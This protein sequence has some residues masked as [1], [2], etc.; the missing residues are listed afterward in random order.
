MI[1]EAS[2]ADHSSPWHQNRAG[3][4][5]CGC[6]HGANLIVL[7]PSQKDRR[8]SDRA[9]AQALDIL[10][11]AVTAYLFA[12]HKNIDFS[13]T[14]GI[15]KQESKEDLNHR[16]SGTGKAICGGIEEERKTW[17][18]HICPKGS[19]LCFQHRS[20]RT[21]HADTRRRDM[22]QPE[23]ERHMLL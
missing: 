23:S 18:I 13:G 15:H 7:C 1:S 10:C 12:E 20:G 21:G 5:F 3:R 22:S 6:W 4:A 14:F 16:I 2:P 9:I 8:G 11:S 19:E 17:G